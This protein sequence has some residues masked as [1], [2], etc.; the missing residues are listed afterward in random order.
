MGLNYSIDK[1]T[2]MYA[3][4]AVTLPFP[5]GVGRPSVYG[6]HS[7]KSSGDRILPRSTGYWTGAGAGYFDKAY[8]AANVV[9]SNTM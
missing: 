6:A 7:G 5:Q 3:T 2:L 1:Q 4:F 8:A 9:Q